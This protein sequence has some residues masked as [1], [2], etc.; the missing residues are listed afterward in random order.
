MKFCH[1]VFLLS[2]FVLVAA[3]CTNRSSTAH[4]P[5][6]NRDRVVYTGSNIPRQ[7]NEVTPFPLAATVPRGSVERRAGDLTPS[8][9]VVGA[10]NNNVPNASENSEPLR[11]TAG[12]AGSY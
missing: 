6:Y 7:R 11:G 10:T 8:E 9:P 1:P 2:A 3:S 5:A 4:R 12:P